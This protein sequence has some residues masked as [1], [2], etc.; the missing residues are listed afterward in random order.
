MQSQLASTVG[1]EVHLRDG[2]FPYFCDVLFRAGVINV[3]W[4]LPTCQSLYI[5]KKN[6]VRL[7]GISLSTTATP[8]RLDNKRLYEVINHERNEGSHVFRAFLSGLWSAGVVRYTVDCIAR[9]VTYYGADDVQ[10]IQRHVT[11]ME[12]RSPP[13]V[14]GKR[15]VQG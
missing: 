14:T 13:C 3:T 10:V 8:S 9:T 4:F 12:M 1:M 7:S 2:G 15:G 11:I 6:R 5:T